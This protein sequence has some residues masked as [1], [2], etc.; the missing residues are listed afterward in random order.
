MARLAVDAAAGIPTADGYDFRR[1][2]FHADELGQVRPC[3]VTGPPWQDGDAWL[4]GCWSPHGS[5]VVA[6]GWERAPTIALGDQLAI[7]IDGVLERHRADVRGHMIGLLGR[8]PVE[9]NPRSGCLCDDDRRRGAADEAEVHRLALGFDFGRLRA[10]PRLAATVLRC[11]VAF[12]DERV[13]PIDRR[14]PHGRDRLLPDDLTWK[15]DVTCRHRGGTSRV[16]MAFASPDLALMIEQGAIVS[17]RVVDPW[18][19]SGPVVAA[20][21]GLERPWHAPPWQ[22]DF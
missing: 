21:G 7:R 11:V 5:S 1:A 10:E 16:T 4:L 2:R 20:R 12:G 15:A 8:H 14:D 3:D 17:V 9:I 6:L 19:W 22:Q 18:A 13:S